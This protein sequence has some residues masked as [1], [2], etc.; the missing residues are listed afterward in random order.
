MPPE[1]K[2]DAPTVKRKEIS[3]FPSG[4]RSGHPPAPTFD[5]PVPSPVFSPTG[6]FVY[7]LSPFFLY[8]VLVPFLLGFFSRLAL[9]PEL[10]PMLV[11]TPAVPSK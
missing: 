10:P 2:P 6:F 7:V 9:M 1:I 5:D 11:P 8:T 3:P 4:Q